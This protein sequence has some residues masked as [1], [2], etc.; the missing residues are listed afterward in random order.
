[1]VAFG[2]ISTA[3]READYIACLYATNIIAIPAFPP[4]NTKLKAKLEKIADDAQPAAVLCGQAIELKTGMGDALF[5]AWDF[6]KVE[7]AKL[8]WEYQL[9]ITPGIYPAVPLHRG[10]LRFSLTTLNTEQQV[11]QA[12]DA[13][14]DI[15][16]RLS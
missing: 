11:N 16:A 13:L 7:A 14:A 2:F 1:M 15:H 9:L 3:K 5:I 8:A 12:I 10:G 6:N 4:S